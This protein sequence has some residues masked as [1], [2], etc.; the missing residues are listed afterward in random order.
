MMLY[1]E[2]LIIIAFSI[3]LSVGIVSNNVFSESQNKENVQT[4]NDLKDFINFHT[5]TNLTSASPLLGKLQSPITIIKFADYQEKFSKMWH[6]KQR[7]ELDSK[8]LANN[9]VNYYFV[10]FTIMGKDSTN[11]ARAAHCAGDQGRYWEYHDVLYYNQG[12]PDKG[13]ADVSSLS[14]YART[15]ELDWTDF[16][17]CL[18]SESNLSKVENNNSVT[19]SNKITGSPAFLIIGPDGTSE[20]IN[21]AH[22]AS[23]FSLSIDLFLVT[24]LIIQDKLPE[25]F[26]NNVMDW[27][28]N[29]ISDFGFGQTIVYLSDAEK[30]QKIIPSNSNMFPD[31]FKKNT[32]WWATG[33]ISE[34]D[35][36]NSIEF[37]IE[38]EIIK[39]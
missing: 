39:V 33:K 20:W 26:R 37:L 16:V 17:E 19:K 7:N 8:Y 31:W 36:L 28:E 5:G 12:D 22:P 2:A 24:D 4:E 34:K 13:W 21:G 32:K 1:K 35:F 18:K 30:I 38:K 15:L 29:E 23:E 6:D 14:Q 10:D 9:L 25:W 11:A 27:S 3:L